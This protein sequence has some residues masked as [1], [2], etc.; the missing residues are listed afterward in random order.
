[1]SEST[2][3]DNVSVDSKLISN[4]ISE[5][6]QKNSQDDGKEN[7]EN[8]KEEKG[9]DEKV[10]DDKVKMW[11]LDNF[12]IGRNLGKG[13]FGNVYLA[14]EKISHFV[15]ALKVL[16]KEQIEKFQVRVQIKREIEIQYHL[17]HPNILRLYGYFYDDTRIYLILEYAAR[18]T[19]FNYLQK[20]KVLPDAVAAKYLYQLTDALDYCHGLGVIHRDIKP[21]N[22]LISVRDDLKIADFGWSVYT[23]DSRRQ[24]IC[25]T[26]DYLPPEMISQSSRSYDS[27]VDHWSVGVLV[28]EMLVGSAP[29]GDA[30]PKNTLLKISQARFTI[31]DSVNK[32]ASDVIQ[33][34][35]KIAPSARASM[36]DVKNSEYVK[37]FYKTSE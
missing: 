29:F 32:K 23:P 8:N 1:M 22:L 24:T 15:I 37:E 9:K 13:K 3:V 14:R 20:H 30:A 4:E 21:E 25:G 33:S 12:E 10:K 31:P 11:K 36:S 6:S 5:N 7:V 16:F 2:T 35:L 18:G 27:K 28:Y 19:L 17:R 26:L 34:L